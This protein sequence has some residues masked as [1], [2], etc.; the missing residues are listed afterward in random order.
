MNEEAVVLGRITGTLSPIVHVVSVQVGPHA[1]VEAY[2][3]IVGSG[4]QQELI[5]YPLLD[6]RRF[7]RRLQRTASSVFGP[8]DPYSMTEF[9]ANK[10][11]GA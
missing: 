2:V 3:N 6:L 1:L 10:L 4:Y 7:K 11:K 5:E 9:I 8:L